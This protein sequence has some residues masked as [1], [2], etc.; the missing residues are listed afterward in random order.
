MSAQPDDLIPDAIVARDRYHVSPRSLPR[1][2][3]N[4]SLGFPPPIIINGRKYRRRCELECWERSR[5]R[6]ASEAA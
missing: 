2:D 4:I 5:V 6:K 3:A 1:W